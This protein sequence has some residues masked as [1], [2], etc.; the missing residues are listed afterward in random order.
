MC[1]IAG[2]AGLSA[3]NAAAVKTMTDL[4]AHRGPDGEGLWRAENARLCLGHR[5]LAVLDLSERAGQPMQSADGS[6]CI[7][8]NGELYNYLEL[9]ERLKQSGS[10]FRTTSDT[11]VIL[12]AY[13]AWGEKCLAEFNGMF[14]FAIYDK[15]RNVLFCARD[16]FGEK[17]FLF[18][19][20][21]GMFAFASEYKALFALEGVD[22]E[23]DR[24]ALFRFLDN[25]AAGLDHHRDT[26]FGGVRQLL[27]A[28]KLVLDLHDLSWTAERYWQGEPAGKAAGI[29][30]GDAARHFRELLTDA[31]RLRL[32]SDVAVGSCLSGGLD[33]S[34]ITC[35]SR[36]I[37][38][39]EK[40]YHVFTGRFPGSPADEGKWADAVVTAT[41]AIQHET[42]PTAEG[43]AGDLPDFIWLNE[44]P[45]DSASQYAQ[46]CVFKLAAENGVTV[47][48]DGQGA[49]E[50]L[51]GYEQYFAYYLR[52][53]KAADGEERLIR[54][55]YPLAL[56]E[57]DRGWKA[58]L[59]SWLRRSAAHALGRGSDLK[60]GVTREFAGE[61]SKTPDENLPVETLH[62]ALHRDACRGFLTT[63]LRYGD[64]NSMAHSREVRLP[65]CD[66]R[67]AEY[68][69][70]LPANLIMGHAQTKYLL[71]QSMR[72]ILPEQVR[73]RWNKQGFLPPQAQW[74]RDGLLDLA[75]EIFNG[76]EF[77]QSPMWDSTWWRHAVHRLRRGE[78][79]L[80]TQVWK[81]FISELWLRYF[82]ERAK[83]LPKVAPL[84]AS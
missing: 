73:T 54:Q 80:A 19:E 46:W 58:S 28:E 70:S 82:V 77:G 44:L 53:H 11:E 84:A 60:F 66:H 17:P 9:T 26:V 2:I 27:P 25:P 41:D 64:R 57:A 36:R 43:I 49:D 31:V 20:R 51:G 83:K 42:M 40:P 59:P 15:R 61:I 29:T 12:E 7:T 3:V 48:L 68:V 50:I 67:I 69:F 71:R 81:P 10:V 79:A 24:Q 30:P 65:F 16:R 72:G 37:L 55:R 74:F 32:R 14:A 13:R 23:V 4:M 22:T 39:D 5:R 35:L 52:S 6:C 62:Q 45:V 47:L 8:Y 75:E 78:D 38:G 18:I 63:L 76:R 33:S 21:P 1:G 34:S 56:S